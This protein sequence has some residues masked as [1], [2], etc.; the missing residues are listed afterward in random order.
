MFWKTTVSH[1]VLFIRK[2]I[3][4]DLKKFLF[5]LVNY[6]LIMLC[7]WSD[8]CVTDYL[9]WTIHQSCDFPFTIFRK[10]YVQLCCLSQYSQGRIHTFP[11]SKVILMCSLQ[12]KPEVFN[13]L[14]GLIELLLI[15][16]GCSLSHAEVED[17]HGIVSSSSCILALATENHARSGDGDPSLLR[18]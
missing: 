9:Q 11:E 17:H 6:C 14:V 8:G 1:F 10:E 15:H 3:I 12:L 2:S 7:I 16:V 13:T 5:M 4:W 18:E